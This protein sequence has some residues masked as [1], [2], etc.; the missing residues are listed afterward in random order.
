MPETSIKHGMTTMESDQFIVCREEGQVAMI[1]LRQGAQ[2]DRKPISADAAIMNPAKKVLALRS[3]ADGRTRLQ[4]FNLD[5]REKL[6]SHEMAEDVVFWKWT[7]PSNLGIV[8]ATAVYHWSLEGK[9]PPVKAFDRHA[10][11]GPN[12]Q[13]INYKVSPDGKWCL[14]GGI[15]A[16]GPGVINGNMQLF[17]IEKN[18]SQPLQGHAASFA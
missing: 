7:S 14:L 15:S 5:T 4:L 11:V 2:V 3:K 10:T 6:G 13:I 12:T 1:D 9:G 8:S 18:V 16:G 17:N